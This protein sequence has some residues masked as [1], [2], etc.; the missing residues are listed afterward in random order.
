MI[1][2]IS[3]ALVYSW[4]IGLIAIACVPFI[5]FA[6]FVEARCTRRAEY[7]EKGVSAS[8]IMEQGIREISLVQAYN[9]E[10]NMADSYAKALEPLSMNKVKEGIAAGFV[11]GFSSF[12]TYSTFAILFYAGLEL[13]SSQKVDFSD[14]FASL[15]AVMFAALTVAQVK[16]RAPEDKT[17]LVPR[18]SCLLIISA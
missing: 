4:Q 10:V 12:A 1:T 6:S 5:L 3:I 18:F 16:M 8:T 14:F 11:F 2:G 15:L 7:V 9:L 17:E 13:M